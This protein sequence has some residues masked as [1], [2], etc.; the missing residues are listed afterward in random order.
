MKKT[1]KRL[2]EVYHPFWK[3]FDENQYSEATSLFAGRLKI[4]GFDLEWFKNKVCLDAGCGSGR[5]VQ[6]MLDLKA[7]E[8]VGIDLD[9]TVAQKNVNDP[10]VKIIQGDIICHL[11]N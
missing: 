1:E 7:K 10:Q 11:V 2:S 6:A 9:P 8:V 3:E 4:N 5:Y